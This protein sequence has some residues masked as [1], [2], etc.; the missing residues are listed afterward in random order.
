MQPRHIGSTLGCGA[1]DKASLFHC[2]PPGGPTLSSLDLGKARPLRQPSMGLLIRQQSPCNHDLVQRLP[3]HLCIRVTPELMKNSPYSPDQGPSP[4]Q[5]KQGV[6]GARASAFSE[7][8]LWNSLC[9][10]VH[11]SGLRFGP[12][13]HGR[14]HSLGSNSH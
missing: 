11:L 3:P 2:L 9:S 5:L 10:Q 8:S 6:G 13:G 14:G 12:D 1:G 4:G 7:S